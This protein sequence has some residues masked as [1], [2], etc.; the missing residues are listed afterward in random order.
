MSKGFIERIGFEETIVLPRSGLQMQKLK[1][2]ENG[3]VR[4]CAA[5]G[6]GICIYLGQAQC[7]PI[8]ETDAMTWTLCVNRLPLAQHSGNKVGPLN[9]AREFLLVRD[10]L[11]AYLCAFAAAICPKGPKI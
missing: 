8:N 2:T 9:A 11:D 4:Y 5:L 1:E 6:D 3:T 7:M 10:H